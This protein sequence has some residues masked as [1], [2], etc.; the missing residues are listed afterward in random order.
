MIIFSDFG[1][2]SQKSILKENIEFKIE[3]KKEGNIR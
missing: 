2:I 1:K 3:T